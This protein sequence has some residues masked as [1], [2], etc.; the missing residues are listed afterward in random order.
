LL[1]PLH[2]ND[3]DTLVALVKVAVTAPAVVWVCTSGAEDTIA[4]LGRKMQA[5]LATGSD[6]ISLRYYAPRVLPALLEVLDEDQL[7]SFHQGVSAWWWLDRKNAVRH[8][9][10]SISLTNRTTGAAPVVEQ[11][12]RLT[13][14]QVDRLLDA[15][16][17]DRVVSM[18]KKISPN[19]T[20]SF[21]RVQIHGL[22]ERYIEAASAFNLHS[23]VECASY[24]A[25][26]LQE[27]PDFAEVPAWQ[28]LMDRVKRGELRFTEAIQE[29][30]ATQDA[31]P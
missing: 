6:A 9:T 20:R 15:S 28:P 14:M 21:D 30:E 5:E 4:C 7:A 26:A 1:L 25:V 27:G 12:L 29:W 3:D 24:F 18:A 10:P 16:F 8:V 23:E 2:E 19:T 31:E 22:A 17:V 13:D 11:P